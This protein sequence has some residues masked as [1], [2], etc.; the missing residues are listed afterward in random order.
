[1]LRG[2]GDK[3]SLGVNETAAD[4]AG[5]RGPSKANPVPADEFKKLLIQCFPADAKVRVRTL[6]HKQIS[7]TFPG[8]FKDSD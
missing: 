7:R 8:L 2:P 5:S 1:M 4:A 6:Y 3:T